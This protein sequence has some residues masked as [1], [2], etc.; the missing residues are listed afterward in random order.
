MHPAR[1]AELLADAGRSHDAL[2]EFKT[3]LLFKDKRLLLLIPIFIYSG[4]EQSF[5]AG[6]FTK[7]PLSSSSSTLP[8]L[9]LHH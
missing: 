7:S 5:N 4:L 1:H 8:S 2:T 6:I 3:I 9:R